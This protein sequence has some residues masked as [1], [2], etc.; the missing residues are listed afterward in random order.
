M[1]RPSLSYGGQPLFYNQNSDDIFNVV[2]NSLFRHSLT[3]SSRCTEK[4]LNL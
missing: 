1:S 4:F 2:S 3:A